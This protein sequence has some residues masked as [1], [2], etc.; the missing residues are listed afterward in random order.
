MFD[1][2]VWL[3]L[4]LLGVYLVVCVKFL[5]VIKFR[6]FEALVSLESCSFFFCFIAVLTPHVAIW[7]YLELTLT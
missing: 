3:A 1:F 7:Y 2:H 6:Q 4:F 5:Y